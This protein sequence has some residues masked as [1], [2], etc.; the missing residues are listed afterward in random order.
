[1][2]L[3]TIAAA[4]AAC[5]VA[6][7]APVT[8]AQSVE[9]DAALPSYEKV[10]G[11]SGNF[12]SIGSDTLNN[13]MTLWAEAYK[14]YYPNVNIQIQ[15]AGSSTAPPALT[16]GTSNFGPM[17]RMM[18][19]KEVEAFE[20]KHGYKPTA[21]PVAI[22]ALAVYVNK[23]N[24]IK[25]LSMPQ[26][27][28]IFSSTRKCGGA[29]DITK[30]GQVGLTGEWADRAIAIYGRNSVSGTYGYF[31]EHA[32]CKGDFKKNVAEQPGSASVVQSVTGQ[33]NAIGYSGIG[34]KTSGVRAV[35]LA[36]K[37][38]QPFVEAD[39][40][41]A[42]DGT[43]PLARVLYVYVNKKPNQPLPPMEREFFRMVLSKQ[44]QTVV[45]KDGF[46]PLPAKMADKAL[47]EILK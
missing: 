11:V 40:K 12:T 3:K 43:Y 14:R 27:D 45:V 28:A 33:I 47:A 5:A 39:A 32:L 1:M 7:F 38:G 25:G 17:S 34:Y 22:D 4:L 26:V 8:M 46:V 36:N 13:L 23:D 18:N 6:T 30:W 37:E 10:A 41:H 19:A 35:P 31:K 20:K 21:I 9:V 29:A 16:E 44:G 42:I 24:P 2:N 15:G